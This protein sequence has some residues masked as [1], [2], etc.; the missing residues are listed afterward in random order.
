MNSENKKEAMFVGGCVRKYFLN[1]KIDDIDIATTLTPEEVIKR[2]ENSE[3]KIKKTGIEH[4]T[5][6][7]VFKDQKF[8]ITTLRQDISTDGRHADIEFTNNWEEDS[9]RRDFTV[10]AIYLSHL[11]KIFDPQNGIKDLKNNKIKFIGDPDKRIKEDYLRILRFLRFSIQ[12]K[13]F[14]ISIEDQKAIRLNLDG[15]TKLSNDRIYSELVKIIKLKNFYDLFK[16]KFLLDIFK[17]IFP[18]FLHLERIKKFEKLYIKNNIKIDKELILATTLIDSSN[19]H[20]YFFH[21]YNVSN[22]TRNSLTFYAKLLK[23]VKSSN[24]FFQK[25]LKKNIF[26]FGVEEIKK[27]FILYNLTNKKTLNDNF[28]E[29]LSKIE[30]TQVPKFPLTGNDLLKKGVKSG[31]RVGKVLREIEKKWIENNFQINEDEIKS[32]VKKNV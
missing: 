26:L 14:D 25:E 20:E 30:N 10:N 18:E 17:L 22:E 24:H 19:N 21:K 1:E 12:Y 9:K 32:L 6:T 31:W 23:Q 15:I 27:I 5:L 16:N 13:S 3:V 11:G 2:F 7:L 28:N 8:E 29:I 4:G